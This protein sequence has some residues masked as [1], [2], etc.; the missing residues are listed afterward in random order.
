[1]KDAPPS[2]K[3]CDER[4]RALAE[5]DR[6]RIVQPCPSGPKNVSE[7]ANHLKAASANISDRL[8]ILKHEAVVDTENGPISRGLGQGYTWRQLLQPLLG[9]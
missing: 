3:E 8:Q 2:S 7:I 5:L 1:M 4:L 6:L 9:V